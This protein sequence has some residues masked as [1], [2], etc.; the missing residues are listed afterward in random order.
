MDNIKK[1]NTN[2]KNLN[3][4]GVW[5]QMQV[6]WQE[7]RGEYHESNETSHEPSKPREDGEK[8]VLKIQ[9]NMGTNFVYDD[10]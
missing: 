9:K 6:P 4:E 3:S 1:N 10:F 2:M 8:E 7:D 5:S